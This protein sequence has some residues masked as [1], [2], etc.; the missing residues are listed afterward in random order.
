MN[1]TRPAAQVTPRLKPRVWQSSCKLP[2]SDEVI[3][4]NGTAQVA[5]PGN[6]I[7]ELT[8]CSK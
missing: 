7:D 4:Q 5:G 8:V 3:S 6:V 2:V 1:P